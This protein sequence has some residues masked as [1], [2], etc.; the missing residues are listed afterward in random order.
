MT[1]ACVVIGMA[2]SISLVL[3]DGMIID[4]IV[5]GLF[6]PLQYLPGELSAVGMMIAHSFLHFP[7]PS[8]SGQAILTM[9]IL[10][11]LSDLLDIS[12][13]VCV[14]AYQY[15]AITMDL[16]IPTNGAL[17]AVITV[18]GISY[19][20]WVKFITK[21]LLVILALSALAIIVASQI[22]LH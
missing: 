12:R 4:T 7:V 22:N 18:A 5:H 20:D 10:I 9:P 8:Y 19:D 2:N 21:K 16:I 15:G 13:Q 1:F 17:M 3:K 6:T 14:L 11:P